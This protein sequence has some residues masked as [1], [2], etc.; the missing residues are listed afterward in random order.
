[1]GQGEAGV[2]MGAVGE[3]ADRPGSASGPLPLEGIVVVDESEGPMAGLITL[4]LADFGARVIKL[5]RPG[6][7][8]WRA[9]AGAALWLRGK[10]SVVVA[11]DERRRIDALARAADLW[12]RGP[13]ECPTGLDDAALAA[14]N[15]R[16]VIGWVS[17][18][19]RTGPYAGYPASEALV[20]AKVGRMLQFRGAV[21][22]PGPVYSALQVATH[23]ASQALLAALLAALRARDRDGVGQVVETSL[24]RGL[25]AYEMNNVLATQVNAMLRA[26]GEPE[27]PAPP[28]PMTV[29]PTL[30]YHPVRAAD[31]RWLQL[32]NLLP[33][34]FRSFIEAIGLAAEMDTLGVS[35]PTEQWPEAERE[36]LRTLILARLQERDAD[37]WQR[38]FVADGGVASHPYQSTQQALADP[39]LVANGHVVPFGEGGCQL[40]L[41]ARLTRTPGRVGERVPAVGADEA[42]V[43]AWLAE[44]AGAAAGQAPAGRSGAAAAPA[45]PAPDVPRAP[46]VRRPPPLAG[47]TVVEA[48]TIIAAPF[49][50]AMLADMGARVIKFEPLDGDPFRGMPPGLGAARVNT[51]KQSIAL[52]LKRPRAREIAHRLIAGA[53]LFIHN[54]RPG[55]PERLGLDWATLSAINPRLVHLSANG[56]GPAGP[57]AL[58]PSTHPIPGAALGGVLW[59]VGGAPDAGPMDEATVRETARRLMRANEVNPDPNTSLVIASAAM[60]GLAARDRLGVGQAIFVDMFGANAWANFDDAIAWPGKPP[61][62]MPDRDGYGLHPLWRLYPC[63]QGWVFLAIDSAQAWEGLRAQLSVEFAAEPALARDY[64]AACAGGAPVSDALARVF[65]HAPAAQWEARLAGRGLGCVQADA[66]TPDAFFLD[67][68]QAID[69]GLCLS[70]EHPQWGAYCRHGALAVFDGTPGV[71]LGTAA[72]GGSTEALLAELGMPGAERAAL[73]EAGVVG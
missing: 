16:L 57:G 18:F 62:P 2:G 20:A 11:G 26:R 36:A 13:A 55:V 8:P 50:A 3:E 31:G 73:R 72:L 67:D 61:R 52:D 1:M 17:A 35:G 15:P 33:H 45:S 39:D 28:D 56:Y 40:G 37:A 6:G 51:G 12:V 29:M 49:G 63:A 38:L 68:P 27:L 58:R 21:S 9:Q 48:A 66:A 19:G 46:A 69:Q 44:R 65:A 34:L 41:L 10:R 7:D 60:L 59:Q 70:A 42:E 71:Y 14:L 30:N 43:V 47:V 24:A 64:P 5:E 54:Y 32:G 25:L 4:V 53:D 22:R 23:A